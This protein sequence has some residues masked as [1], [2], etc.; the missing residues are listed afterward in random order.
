[1]EV[2][3]RQ[4]PWP[5]R[6][7]CGPFTGGTPGPR[8]RALPCPPVEQK[9]KILWTA[10]PAQ[11]ILSVWAHSPAVP[12]LCRAGSPL[13]SRVHDEARTVDLGPTP[14]PE[15]SRQQFEAAWQAVPAGGPPPRIDDYLTQ[16]SPEES[17]SLREDL[18]RIQRDFQ[19]G[20]PPSGYLE[21]EVILPA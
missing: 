7:A 14:Q 5:R 9:G 2:V 10:P 16:V 17:P 19:K 8:A 15:A 20:Q 21:T 6:P 12:M 13:M 11:S 4:P 1:S 3:P 18:Q